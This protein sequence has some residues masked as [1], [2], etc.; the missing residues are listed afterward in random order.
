MLSVRAINRALQRAS[1]VL[2]SWC[3]YAA[4]RRRPSPAVYFLIALRFKSSRAVPSTAVFLYPNK[5]AIKPRNTLGRGGRGGIHSSHPRSPLQPC[6]L[7][8]SALWRRCVLPDDSSVDPSP[9]KV[10]EAA[11]VHIKLV[12]GRNYENKE[13]GDGFYLTLI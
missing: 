12:V 3:F 13:V 9:A 1:S 4:V 2:Y 8:L 5:T 6:M 11:I 7:A 10:C